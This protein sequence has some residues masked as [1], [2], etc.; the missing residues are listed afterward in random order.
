MSQYVSTRSSEFI[1][2][3]IDNLKKIFIKHN[4]KWRGD[5]YLTDDLTFTVDKSQAA[6][7]YLLKLGDTTIINGDRISINSGNRTLIIDDSNIIKL[8][9]RQ[10]LNREINSFIIINESD[11]TEPI[12]YESSIFLI[13][14]INKKMA[15]SYEW[16][17][18]L[19]NVPR[20]L[21]STR[22]LDGN[23]GS[24][25]TP[26]NYKPHN[27]PHLINITYGNYPDQRSPNI[28][29]SRD[30]LVSRFQFV[31]ESADNVNNIHTLNG[32]YQS[33]PSSTKSNLEGYKGAI[34]IILLM[35]VLILCILASK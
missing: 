20:E 7:F 30:Y 22:I 11:T 16:G 6:C 17:M 26:I 3:D 33:K 25:D 18:D 15:L 32:I 9:D 14:D 23:I 8:I 34:M 31:L 28:L 10:L 12:T 2:K 1:T 27:S 5:Y 13:S 4:D 24:S 21:I 35:V 29:S 19:I